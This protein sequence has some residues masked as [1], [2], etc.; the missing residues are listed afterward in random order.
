MTAT[1]VVANLAKLEGWYL[2]GDGAEVRI[3][4]TFAFQDYAQT[5]A[6]VNTVAWDA[7]AC[8]HHP[9]LQ[10]T[11]NRC[12]VRYNTHEVG[13]LSRTDFECAERADALINDKLLTRVHP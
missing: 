6:F 7:Q 12:V 4:K 5:M 10:V 1:E 8:N 9:E 3:E 11:F 2:C 13:G